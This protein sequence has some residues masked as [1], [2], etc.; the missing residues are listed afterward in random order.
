MRNPRVIFRQCRIKYENMS[1]GRTCTPYV[2]ER[3]LAESYLYSFGACYINFNEIL[4]IVPMGLFFLELYGCH[5]MIDAVIY[6]SDIGYK[7]I[8]L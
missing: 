7:K 6:K 4:H 8:P 3:S 5:I 1:Q 2:G